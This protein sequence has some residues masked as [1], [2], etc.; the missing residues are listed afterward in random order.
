MRRDDVNDNS[1]LVTMSKQLRALNNYAMKARYGD[2]S[3]P[4]STRSILQHAPRAAAWL[5]SAKQAD[6]FSIV[7]CFKYQCSEGECEKH[8]VWKMLLDIHA[9]AR[10]DARGATSGAW[11]I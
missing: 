5:D 9:S 4:L 1:V 7:E 6:V 3:I 8:P 2:R 11:T 10:I